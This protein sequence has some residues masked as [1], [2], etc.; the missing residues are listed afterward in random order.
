M[1]SSGG[2]AGAAE[3]VEDEM[4]FVGAGPNN[5]FEKGAW[6]LSWVTSSLQSRGAS[7]EILITSSGHFP[8]G[9]S[10]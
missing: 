3:A 5:P 7:I 1:Q 8:F 6:F 4:A 2:G 10:S 9:F